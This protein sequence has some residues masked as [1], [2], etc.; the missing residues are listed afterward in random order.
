METAYI[1]KWVITLLYSIFSPFCRR[2]GSTD[3]EDSEDSEGEGG[4]EEDPGG[5]DG[6]AVPVSNG[7]GEQT[8]AERTLGGQNSRDWVV[9]VGGQVAKQ[10]QAAVCLFGHPLIMGNKFP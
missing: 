1:G 3:S 6:E 2:L 4:E 9:A 8:E 10:I 7:C 5:G